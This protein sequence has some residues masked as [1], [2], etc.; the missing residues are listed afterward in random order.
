MYPLARA[1]PRDSVAGMAWHATRPLPR[2][3]LTLAGA[4]AVVIAAGACEH[5]DAP[6]GTPTASPPAPSPEPTGLGLPTVPGAADQPDPVAADFGET[7]TVTGPDLFGTRSATIEVTLSEPV[8][9]DEVEL[10]TGV[11]M[12]PE[13]DV[14]VGVEVVVAGVDGTYELNPL[15][16]HLVPADQ[17]TTSSSEPFVWDDPTAAQ[18]WANDGRFEPGLTPTTIAAGA[19]VSGY[20]VFDVESSATEDAAIV[21]EPLLLVEGPPSAYWLLG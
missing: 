8:V 1:H 16:F 3:L 15:N 19:Q 7:V 21:L 12:T 11:V 13:N 14:Y 6:T 9:V 20:I 17:A 18:G 10:G 5:D 4:A 2:V